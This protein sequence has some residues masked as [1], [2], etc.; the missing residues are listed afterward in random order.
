VRCKELL[1]PI[2]FERVAEQGES[3]R[4]NEEARVAASE[5][6]GR[7]GKVTGGQDRDG[8]CKS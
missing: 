6:Q 2:G 5:R 7:L 4:G 8:E 1:P 3:P